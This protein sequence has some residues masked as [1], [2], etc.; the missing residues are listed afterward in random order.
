MYQLRDRDAAH[1]R[2]AREVRA[3]LHCVRLILPLDEYYSCG[4]CE[5]RHDLCARCC[6]ADRE[7]GVARGERGLAL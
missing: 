5:E 1:L 3:C 6:G 2:L 7:L 4:V